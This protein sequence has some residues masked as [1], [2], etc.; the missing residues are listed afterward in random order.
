MHSFKLNDCKFTLS[1]NGRKVD[2]GREQGKRGDEERNGGGGF[3]NR[4]GEDKMDGQ[5]AMRMNGN[6]QLMGVWR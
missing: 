5:M 4:C 2:G 6:L 3:R 1:R